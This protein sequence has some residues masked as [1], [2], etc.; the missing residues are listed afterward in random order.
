MTLSR[1]SV[2]IPAHQEERQIAACLLAL[3]EQPPVPDVAREVIVVA[4][5]CTDRTAEVAGSQT[6]LLQRS[7]WTLQV[8]DLPEGGKIGALNHGDA[9][10]SGDLRLYLD[11]D[12]R[13]GFGL[14]PALC[15][16]LRQPGPRYAGARLVVP[17]PSSRVSA[18]YA[19][20][21]QKLP[22]VAQGVTGAGLFAV[23]AE[24]RA[25]WGRFPDIIADD[26]FVRLHFTPAERTRVEATYLWPISERLNPLIKVRRRQDA[27]TAQLALLY[28]ELARNAAGDRASWRQ[29]LRLGLAD[30]EGF[31]A[32]AL[33]SLGVRMRKPAGNWDRN[34]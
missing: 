21:W 23:N 18:A 14:I 1:L 13:V 15:N 3:A 20:F 17:P 4:N 24:G 26:A 34:R 33:V 11:A 28:P 31:A 5:G 27:G 19:R 9:E 6:A 22:F 2:I 25:R 32:Y 12:I 29:A 7:G 30:P 10:A 8:I 16:A